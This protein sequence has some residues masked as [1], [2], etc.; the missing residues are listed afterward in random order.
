MHFTCVSSYQLLIAHFRTNMMD[1]C[2]TVIDTFHNQTDNALHLLNI[3]DILTVN[4]YQHNDLKVVYLQHKGE[5]LPKS[6]FAT[7]EMLPNKNYVNLKCAITLENK[8]LS[9]QEL[10]FMTKSFRTCYNLKSSISDC[11]FL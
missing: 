4:V 5:S 1:S 3:L 8:Q 2:P 6:F 11:H 7:S 9:I 10:I